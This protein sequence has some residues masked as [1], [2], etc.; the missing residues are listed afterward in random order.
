MATVEKFELAPASLSDAG[1]I[2]EMSRRWIEH[3]LPWRYR[4]GA[5]TRQ[6]RGSETEV[7][8]A[9]D[10]QRV[11]GFGV[12]EFDF[13]ARRA[14]LVLL[15]VQPSLRRHGVGA[16]LFGWLH[17]IARRAGTTRIHLEVRADNAGA[18]T[19]YEALGFRMIGRLRGYY[20]GRLDALKMEWT[21]ASQH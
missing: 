8:V 15:A 2:A 1:L 19:F 21:N 17:E 13:E 7:V 3:G 9:R 6:I 16:A 20:N 12:A 11:I 18:R 14:H 4:A 5:I 10:R